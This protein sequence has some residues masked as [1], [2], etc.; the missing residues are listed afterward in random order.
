MF[1]FTDLD[2]MDRPTMLDKQKETK[3]Y[4]KTM[5]RLKGAFLAWGDQ[6]SELLRSY[7]IEGKDNKLIESLDDAAV[8]GE[9]TVMKLTNLLVRL[10]N[11]LNDMS[12]RLEDGTKWC[13]AVEIAKMAEETEGN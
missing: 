6:T 2:G 4:W 5:Y 7:K 8:R 12:T 3:A 13:T 1:Q 11:Y 9:I 10:D